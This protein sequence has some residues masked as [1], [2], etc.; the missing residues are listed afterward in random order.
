MSRIIRKLFALAI[1]W[2]YRDDNPT[3]RL[4]IAI[5]KIDASANLPAAEIGRLQDVLDDHPNCQSANA[6]RLL[7]LT[8]ARRG[9]GSCRRVGGN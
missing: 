2:G 5:R 7:M 4:G 9:E 6:V 1:R 3:K 8:G